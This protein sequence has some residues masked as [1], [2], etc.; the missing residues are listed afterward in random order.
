ML[1]LWGILSKHHRA[2]QSKPLH[3]DPA[4]L[5]FCLCLCQVGW[6]AAVAVIKASHFAGPGR[7]LLDALLPIAWLNCSP[8]LLDECVSGHPPFLGLLSMRYDVWQ[9]LGQAVRH[10]PAKQ[11]QVDLRLCPV[12]VSRFAASLKH[13]VSGSPPATLP[14]TAK[15]QAS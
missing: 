1:S 4:R 2:S 3:S 10:G 12:F 8:M 5:T 15:S 9:S 6:Q 14:A 7:W 13:L 11:S